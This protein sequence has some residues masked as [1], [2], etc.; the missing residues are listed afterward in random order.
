MAG[1]MVVNWPLPAAS[2]MMVPNWSEDDL[3]I[4]ESG[5]LPEATGAELVV[6]ADCDG[7]NV[8]VLLET[9]EELPTEVV[10]IA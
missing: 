4:L 7:P 2:T 3:V 5:V 6:D 8:Y 9:V 1:L 10:E